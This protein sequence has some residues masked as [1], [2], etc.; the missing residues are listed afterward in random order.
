MYYILGSYI[1]TYMYVCCM[2]AMCMY[3]TYI[4]VHVH[5][6]TRCI[7]VH[8]CICMYIMCTYAR[9]LHLY[10]YICMYACVG[11]SKVNEGY[12]GERLFTTHDWECA[13]TWMSVHNRNGSTK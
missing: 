4:H 2:Y 9:Y 12:Y 3:T 11:H 1:R 7:H 5:M 8:V 10:M 13:L 6:Y